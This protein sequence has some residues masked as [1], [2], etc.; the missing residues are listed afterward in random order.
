MRRN[1]AEPLQEDQQD[2]P[3]T[4]KNC[5]KRPAGPRDDGGKLVCKMKRSIEIYDGIQKMEMLYI[6]LYESYFDWYLYKSIYLY[7]YVPN[8]ALYEAFWNSQGLNCHWHFAS[9]VL[10]GPILKIVRTA[11]LFEPMYIIFN[12]LAGNNVSITFIYL[13]IHHDL[14]KWI[15]YISDFR[16]FNYMTF[17]LFLVHDALFYLGNRSWSWGCPQWKSLK[18]LASPSKNGGNTKDGKVQMVVLP[19]STV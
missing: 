2:P 8:E 9:A 6:Y 16:S 15:Q 18:S 12:H 1:T 13:Y 19:I 5:K 4:T 17:V 10:I 11:L 3:K 7:I 14:Y